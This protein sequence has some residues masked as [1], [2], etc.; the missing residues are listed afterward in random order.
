M[1]KIVITV[2]VIIVFFVF[3]LFCFGLAII[4]KSRAHNIKLH[5]KQIEL[6]NIEKEKLRKKIDELKEDS[7][8]GE[9]IEAVKELEVKLENFEKI[10][11]DIKDTLDGLPKPILF[12]KEDG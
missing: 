8:D 6:L 10:F 5:E 2:V 1:K 4:D 11:D 3:S 12:Y 7:P 9:N